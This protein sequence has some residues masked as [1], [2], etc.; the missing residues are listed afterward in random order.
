LAESDLFGGSGAAELRFAIDRDE[1]L[2]KWEMDNII[3]LR[4][5]EK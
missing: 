5:R 1:R 4:G 3:L 2:M